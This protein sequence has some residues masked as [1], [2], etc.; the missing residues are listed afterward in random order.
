MLDASKNCNFTLRNFKFP[1]VKLQNRILESVK[2]Q[3]NNPTSSS[4][5]LSEDIPA[6]SNQTEMSNSQSPVQVVAR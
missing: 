4:P 2:T 5:P 1:E 6:T 3:L